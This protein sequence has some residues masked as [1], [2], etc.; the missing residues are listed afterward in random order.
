MIISLMVL[1]SSCVEKRIVISKGAFSTANNLIEDDMKEQGYI[2]SGLS[3][4]VKNEIYVAGTSYSQYTGYGSKMEN[5]LFEYTTYLF[6]DTNDYFVKYTLKSH[7]DYSMQ[8]VKYFES[9]SVSNCEA[10]KNYNAF[11]GENGIINTAVNYL[12]AHPDTIVQ[13]LIELF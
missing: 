3:T 11:C 2:L 13:I 7:I 1:L 4:D 12:N 8:G 9:I 6:K 5:R 10:N